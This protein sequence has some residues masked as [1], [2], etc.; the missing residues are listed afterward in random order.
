MKK[1]VEMVLVITALIWAIG[2]AAQA[3]KPSTEAKIR[4]LL[5]EQNWQNV[6]LSNQEDYWSFQ[7]ES[8]IGDFDIVVAGALEY[9]DENETIDPFSMV[10]YGYTDELG[11]FVVAVYDY[12]TGEWNYTADGKRC[13]EEASG[14]S[15]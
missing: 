11:E 3:Q 12:E 15:I 10:V 14:A 4:A 6:V 1:F 13:L 7:A 2:G 5:E 9:D 8:S